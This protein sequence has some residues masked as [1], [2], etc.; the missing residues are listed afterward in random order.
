[1]YGEGNICIFLK[2]GNG[3]HEVCL[4]FGFGWVLTTDIAKLKLKLE[5]IIYFDWAF[6][7]M[8]MKKACS[9]V[10]LA[11]TTNKTHNFELYSS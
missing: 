6:P 8:C 5:T 4:K 1:M 2:N 11:N 3:L 9:S 7:F 10:T